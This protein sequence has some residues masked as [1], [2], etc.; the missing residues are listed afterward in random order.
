MA[1]NGFLSVHG[2]LIDEPPFMAAGIR[3]SDVIAEM[4]CI[5]PLSVRRLIEELLH[6]EILVMQVSRK[7]QLGPPSIFGI[8]DTQQV[9]SHAEIFSLRQY[10]HRALQDFQN[11][12]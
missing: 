10:T 9:Y 12:A 6:E 2:I 5:N 1:K 8:I 11:T 7:R 4:V 3:E